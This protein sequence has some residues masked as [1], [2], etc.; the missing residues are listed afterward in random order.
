MG[1]WALPHL[2]NRVG[3]A[4]VV[5]HRPGQN[6]VRVRRNIVVFF[7]A[8]WRSVLYLSVSTFNHWQQARTNHPRTRRPRHRPIPR[9]APVV[10]TTLSDL[11]AAAYVMRAAHGA[12][13]TAHV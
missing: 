3:C 4:T 1:L 7:Y 9:F 12:R 8:R 11:T 6:P 13:A 2:R 10:V 5:D